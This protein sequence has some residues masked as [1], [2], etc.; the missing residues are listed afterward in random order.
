MTLFPDMEYNSVLFGADST[1]GIVAVEQLADNAVR[2]YVRRGLNLQSQDHPFTPFLLMEE[3]KLLAEFSSPLE[4]KSLKGNNTYR[5]LVLFESWQDCSSAKN[6]LYKNARKSNSSSQAPCLY[7]SDPIQ[8]YLMLSGKT[9]FKNMSFQDVHRLALDIETACEPGYEFSNP[10]READRII[11]IALMDNRGFSR[12]IFGRDLDEA[13]MLLELNKVISLLDPDVLEGHNIFN[14][15]LEYITTRARM[16]GVTL[17]WGRDGSEPVTRRSRFT[18]AE[19]IIDYTRMDIFGRHVIDTLFLLQHYDVAQR[20]LESYGL[21]YAARH[22]G[23]AEDERVYIDGKDINWAFEHD[24]EALIKYNLADAKETL[25]L[26]ELLGYSFFLQAK[27]FPFSYQNIPMRGNATKVDALLVREYLKQG[28]SIPA[29]GKKTDFEGGYTDIFVRGSLKDVYHCDVASLYPSIMVSFAMKPRG[30]SLEV[31]LPLLRG[32]KAFRLEA[33]RLARE[34]E[35]TREADY[36]Q[37][38]QQT[39]KILINSFYGY[40]GSDFHHFSDPETAA[41]ITR[42]GRNLIHR[43]LEWLRNEGATPIEV[44]TDGIY[45][46]L[47]SGMHTKQADVF[48]QRLSQ[49]LPQGIDIEMDGYFPAMF[50]YK[51][52]NYALL[53]INN[54]ILIK[55]SALKSRGMEKYLRIF[56][57]A[58]LKLLMQDK[59]RDAFGLY[60]DTYHKI[61][62]HEI[63]IS[64]LAKT[65]TLKDSPAVYREKRAAK[66]RNASAAYELAI[67]SGREYRAGDQIS[68][69]VTGHKKSVRI[70][71]NCRFVQ[72]YDPDYPDENVAYYKARL[73]DL[74]KKFQE[75]IQGQL[76]IL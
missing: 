67:P 17:D 41:A 12:V 47:P 70:Y 53:D 69:Y 39:F 22:F 2:L 21:K 23:L 31:F 57:S 50:S 18:M 34:V 24:P 4:I 54:S 37:T 58:L 75:F 14:F 28:V 27:M 71:E 49:E 15:D 29:P 44:D 8:Q 62:N 60:Q 76:P 73:E 3:D 35:D 5:Y 61:E 51:S 55:G 25:S 72:Q 66:K 7:L 45:F 52:K 26:S 30:D 13:R 6:H 43:I 64:L 56:L 20:N 74:W 48:I 38:L 40:L 19:R 10:Q 59:V 32:L 65:E 42:E 46:Q 1:Q 63:D 33:K 36:Y 16:H 9:L 11:S 68:Y